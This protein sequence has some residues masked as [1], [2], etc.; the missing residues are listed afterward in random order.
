MKSIRDKIIFLGGGGHAKVLIELIN[1]SGKLE[2]IG[3]L[4]SEKKKGTKVLN[5]YILGT[6]NLLGELYSKG[7]RNVCIA[8]GSIKENDKR[9]MLYDKV[10]QM[11]FLIPSL[12]HPR[13]FVSD[14]LNISEGVQIMAGAIVQTGAVIGENTIVN[15]GAVIEHDCIIGKNVHICPGSVICG[16]TVIGDNSFIGAGTTVIQGIK[17]D[18]NVIIGAGSVVIKDVPAGV[19]V[20]GVPV[21]IV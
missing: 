15:T 1:N 20:T 3:V 9:K 11:G 4:D 12:I 2:I 10:K 6:D 7:I 14:F 17:I 19:I 5:V 16:G 13:A 21:K 8:V 18:K